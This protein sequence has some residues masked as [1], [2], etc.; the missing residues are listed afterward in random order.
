MSPGEDR[1]PHEAVV[2][3]AAFAVD[4]MAGNDPLQPVAK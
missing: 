2:P 3:T 4:S 1:F